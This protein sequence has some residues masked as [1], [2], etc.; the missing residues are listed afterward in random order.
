MDFASKRGMP[1][2]DHRCDDLYSRISRRFKVLSHLG[3]LDVSRAV[4]CRCFFVMLTLAWFRRQD[5]G[6]T[7]SDARIQALERL[8]PHL[9]EEEDRQ[10]LVLVLEAPS[11]AERFADDLHLIS[12]LVLQVHRGHVLTPLWAA[13]LGMKL[14]AKKSLAFGAAKLYVGEVELPAVSKCK[15]LGPHASVRCSIYR[16]PG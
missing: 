13:A 12:R 5:Q 15:D 14:N 8:S 10:C 4:P 1:F 2:A 9:R 6:T 7:I 3:A 16:D 11:A